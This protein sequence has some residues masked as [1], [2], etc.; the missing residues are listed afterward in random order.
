MSLEFVLVLLMQ[1][2]LPSK[3]VKTQD[4][5]FSPTGP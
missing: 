3:Q 1:P 2:A 4:S 5:I